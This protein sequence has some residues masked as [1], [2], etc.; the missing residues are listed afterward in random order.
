MKSRKPEAVKFR[1]WVTSEVLPAIRKS[2][3][4]IA[5]QEKVRTG[6]MSEAEF[7]SRAVADSDKLQINL[8][9][10]GRAPWLVNES[11][12]YRLVMRSAKPKAQV[13]LHTP[14]LARQT[15]T[16]R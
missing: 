10:R 14:T 9:L 12:L 4:Y 8:G 5:G 16:H 13:G 2:G 11:G 7:M 1:H 6:E 15:E 3:G